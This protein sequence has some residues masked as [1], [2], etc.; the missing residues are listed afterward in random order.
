MIIKRYI[1]TPLLC[2][3]AYLPLSW[4]RGIGSLMGKLAFKFSSQ[5]GKTRLT[6]NLLLTGM[7][8]EEE[9]SVM[10]RRTAEELCKTLVETITVA[11]FRNKKY[12]ASL[13]HEI[14][15]IELVEKEI[16][17]GKPIVFLTPHIGNFEIAL[18]A[19]AY[20]LKNNF[21]VLYKPSKD[22]WYNELML[23]GRSEDNIK[24]V[25]TTSRGIL[26]LV[27]ALKKHEYIGILPD[28]VASQGDGVWVDFFGE[29]VFAATLAAK[30]ASFKDAATFV[31][32]SR[33]VKNGFIAEYI[34]YITT[35]TEPATMTQEIYKIIETIVLKAREQYFWSYDRFR[36]P[37]HAPE[38]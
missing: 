9:L 35:S 3:L 38:E 6:N 34:P 7:C 10:S 23:N 21:T 15:G 19:T 22:K 32:S 11:W 25:P 24:P 8:N 33:R 17:Q 31:V 1:F 20:R 4:L 13:V 30:M 5:K 14:H 36:R 37:S 29:R 16:A 26:A 28:S 27:K 18:K 12:N 2:V